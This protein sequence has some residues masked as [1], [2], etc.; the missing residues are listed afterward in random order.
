MVAKQ[1][2]SD[3]RSL[4][5]AHTLPPERLSAVNELLSSPLA[6][7]VLHLLLNFAIFSQAST[8]RVTDV[9]QKVTKTCSTQS[10]T[11]AALLIQVSDTYRARYPGELVQNQAA[12]SLA[13]TF[14]V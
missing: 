4:F 10:D 8:S 1:A 2:W 5:L 12:W 9:I 7:I 3:L 11:S 13:A 6:N 14:T